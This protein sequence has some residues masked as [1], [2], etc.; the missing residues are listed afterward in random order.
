ME[1]E[2]KVSFIGKMFGKLFYWLKWLIYGIRVTVLASMQ[3]IEL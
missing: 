3:S 2:D 1:N